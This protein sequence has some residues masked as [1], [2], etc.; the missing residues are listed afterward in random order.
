M[1]SKSKELNALLLF[2]EIDTL[3]KRFIIIGHLF[4][5]SFIFEIDYFYLKP[6]TSNM[7]AKRFLKFK[8]VFAKNAEQ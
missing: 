7:F 6:L 2:L 5:V 8:I 3:A 1:C 4:F